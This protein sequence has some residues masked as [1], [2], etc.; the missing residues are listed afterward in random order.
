MRTLATRIAAA[1]VVLLV[2]AAPALAQA[3]K[4]TTAQQYE[5]K[6]WR[7]A[8]AAAE[9]T[10]ARADATRL[11]ADASEAKKLR[12]GAAKARAQLERIGPATHP[13]L[14]ADHE[15][16]AA[17]EKALADK[18]GAGKNDMTAALADIDAAVA[19][20]QAEVEKRPAIEL[21][22]DAVARGYRQRA[23]DLKAKL[24]VYGKPDHPDVKPSY[25][26][27]AAFEK[28]LAERVAAGRKEAGERAAA[29]AA[30]VAKTVDLLNGYFEPAF[31]CKLEPPH[32][33]ERVRDWVK[34]LKSWN[35]SR[36]KG[37]A[38][39]DKLVAEHPEYAQDRRVLRLRDWFTGG[40]PKMIDQAVEA[41]R[42][43][44]AGALAFGERL[45]DPKRAS[46]HNFAYE[47]WV[48]EARRVALVSIEAGKALAVFEPD[49]GIAPKIA[50]YEAFLVKLAGGEKAALENARVPQPG[51]TDAAIVAAAESA[52]KR[53]GW[54]YERLVVT[55][56]KITSR[57]YLE[58][59]GDT[60]CLY[61]FDEI[62]G[63]TA[64]KIGAEYWVV[65]YTW[66]FFRSANTVTPLNVWVCSGRFPSKRILKENI[67]K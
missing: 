46:E 50:A 29:T 3:A 5:L 43:E 28:V 41:Q 14:A 62:W 58:W 61:D 40:L 66:R 27:V 55:A 34:D 16:M 65:A 32:T 11:A 36:E 6:K 26:R 18:L 57:K 38:A 56:P 13:E 44:W 23:A 30:D 39:L 22:D 67:A 7:D 1:L 63:S 47:E 49:P 25:E 35:E 21:A 42:R 15:R 4:L 8:I 10:L 54:T 59:Q 31:T 60:L 53:G 24:A 64:E 48:K 17:H 51:T 19:A 2:A 45:I 20:A 37:L 12:D 52:V 9:R 33:E